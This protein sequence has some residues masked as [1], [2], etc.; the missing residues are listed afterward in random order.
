MKI[1]ISPDQRNYEVTTGLTVVATPLEGGLSR[2]RADYLGAPFRVNVKW[3]VDAAD[4][5]YLQAFYRSPSAADNGANG[6]Y[7][8]LIIDYAT[9]TTYFA[10]IVPQTWKPVASR[11][12]GTYIVSCTLEVLPLDSTFPDDDLLLSNHDSLIYGG[13]DPDTPPPDMMGPE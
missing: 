11:A 13:K 8:D 7:V 2:L 9:L 10:Q 12:G 6:F 4:F 5:N 3:T 1:G